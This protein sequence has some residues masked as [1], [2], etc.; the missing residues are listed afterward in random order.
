MRTWGLL[1][2]RPKATVWVF[3]DHALPWSYHLVAVGATIEPL[4]LA[5]ACASPM[6]GS[7]NAAV[8]DQGFDS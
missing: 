1:R 8:S 3:R 7:L 4:A 2:H 6:P 5:E